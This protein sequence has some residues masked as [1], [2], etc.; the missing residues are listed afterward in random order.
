MKSKRPSGTPSIHPPDLPVRP[1][2]TGLPAGRLAD[3]E[4]YSGLT[5]ADYDVA[6]QVARGVVFE[7]TRCQRVILA[8]THLAGLRL[9][10]VRLDTCDATGADWEKA[11]LDRVEF[12]GCRLTGWKALEA[13]LCDVLFTNCRVD[14][15]LL[16]QVAC[17][18]VRFENCV[19]REV[20]LREADLRGVT[21]TAC[22]L[23]AADLWGAKLADTDVRG[24][25]V[26]GVQLTAPDA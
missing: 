7:Q 25:Q 14:L 9:R 11:Q 13:R 20:S 17:K 26:E 2:A 10:D 21:F 4:L 5:I 8:R 16:W 23:R 24:C 3:D 18:A 19:L 6:D 12:V 1:R 15:A 22:D